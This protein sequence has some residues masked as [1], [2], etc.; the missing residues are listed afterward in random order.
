MLSKPQIQWAVQQMEKVFPN[1]THTELI[2]STPFQILVA[3]M[4]S[5]QATDASVNRVLPKLFHDYPDA[6]AMAAAPESRI[7]ADIHSIGLSKTKAHRLKTMSQQLLDEYQGHVPDN[8]KDLMSLP[9]VGRKTANVVLGDAFGIPAF[10]VDTH[11]T[12][13]SKRLPIVPENASVDQVEAALEAALPQTEWI[14]AH[15]TMVLFGRNV[16]KARNPECATCPL[17]KICATGQKL[18]QTK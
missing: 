8:R 10:G 13:I 14:Q 5:A 15:H 1:Q 7:Q 4:L 18:T 12:R 3:I 9:G 6:Q 16:C 2:G 11:I 17:L